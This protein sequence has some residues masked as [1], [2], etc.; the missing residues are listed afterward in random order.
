MKGV[1][2]AAE[3]CDAVSGRKRFRRGEDIGPGNNHPLMHAGDEVGFHLGNQRVA[4]AL[5]HFA[6]TGFLPQGGAHF[7]FVQ[8]LT[9]GLPGLAFTRATASAARSSEEELQQDAGVEV[10][11]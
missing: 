9:G 4:L 2:R 1:Q 7:Q 3:R 5:R 8:V 6:T 10:A 11:H